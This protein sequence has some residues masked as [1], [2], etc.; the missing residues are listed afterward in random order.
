[1][2]MLFSDY[3]LMI[4]NK[5]KANKKNNFKRILQRFLILLNAS[6]L[7]SHGVEVLAALMRAIVL[8]STSNAPAQ[9]NINCRRK[10]LHSFT[11]RETKLVRGEKC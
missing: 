7:F 10:K 8:V 9:M 5:I 2:S 4:A 6:A 3:Q 1:M 11:I